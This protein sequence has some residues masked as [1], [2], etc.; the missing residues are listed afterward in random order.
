MRGVSQ[1]L[2]LVRAVGSKEIDAGLRDLD[3]KREELTIKASEDPP[4]AQEALAYLAKKRLLASNTLTSSN[5]EDRLAWDR[6]NRW[7]NDRIA[8][9]RPL[10]EWS[11]S[12]LATLNGIVVNGA[13]SIRTTP[14]YAGPD[15][16]LQ[17]E[18][19]EPEL[20][21]L[22]SWIRSTSNH[23]ALIGATMYIAVVTIHPFENGNGRTARLAADGTLLAEGL[24]PLCFLSPI[25]TH[26]A[27]ML[28]GPDRDPVRSVRLV[29]DA[30]AESYTT[31][32]GRLEDSTPS[33]GM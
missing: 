10:R 17:P 26:V 31:V 25:A 20:R 7:L 3:A 14:I 16:Y 12:E 9:D 5:R 15:Q 22:E 1:Y 19:I 8:D 4:R 32:L 33:R 27:Q 23:P 21:A 2:A 11:H 13:S 29:L 24:L 28:S 6:A 30:I 18:H